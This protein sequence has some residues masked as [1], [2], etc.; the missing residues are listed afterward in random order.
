M[1]E[2]ELLGLSCPFCGADLYRGFD[3]CPA[4][5]NDIPQELLDEAAASPV[6][7]SE[8]ILTHFDNLEEQSKTKIGTFERL[9]KDP[10]YSNKVFGYGDVDFSP[11][12]NPLMSVLEVE[13]CLGLI[14]PLLRYWEGVAR[15]CGET[16]PSAEKCTLGQIA[17]LLDKSSKVSLG[18]L[19]SDREN[20]VRGLPFEAH[21]EDILKHLS[22]FV[23]IRN[24]ASHKNV[25]SGDVFAKTFSTYKAFY[26]TYMPSLLAKKRPPTLGTKLFIA[27][28]EQFPV[29]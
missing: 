22:Y 14:K 26:E 2:L 3:I 11:L 15:T 28:R 13:L 27:L 9:A 4:C 8:Y 16:L 17:H 20:Y 25:V 18:K 7:S 21:F 19:E 1:E 12:I 10:M 23:S 5:G 24:N 6:A 29:F